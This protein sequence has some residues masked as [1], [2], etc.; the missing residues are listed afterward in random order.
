MQVCPVPGDHTAANIQVMLENVMGEWDLSS[1]R[2][3]AITTDN[4]SNI[5]KAV[6]DQG[7]WLQFSLGLKYQY[8]KISHPTLHFLCSVLFFSF[9]MLFCWLFCTLLLG[10]KHIQCFGHRLNLAVRKAL[11]VKVDDKDLIAPTITAMKKIFGHFSRCHKKMRQLTSAQVDSCYRSLN[12]YCQHIC[13]LSQ[14][15]R[16]P[17]SIGRTTPGEL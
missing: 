11:L 14:I 17:S 4:G 8:G 5:V 12:A 7:M 9:F 10:W 3:T 13:Q 2:L 6:R 16:G 1:D 15:S